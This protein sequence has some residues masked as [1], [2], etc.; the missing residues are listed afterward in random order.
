MNA[1]YLWMF[2]AVMVLLSGVASAASVLDNSLSLANVSVSP[3]PVI[4]GGNVTI[5][6]Q[7]YDSYGSFLNTVNLQA[8]GSYPIINFSP[9]RTTDIANVNPGVNPQQYTYTFA[10]PATTPSGTYKIYFNATYYGLG[11]TEVLASSSMPVTFY[12]QNKPSIKVMLVNPSPPALYSGYNQTVRIEIENVGYGTARNISVSVGAN[13]G[14]SILSSVTTFFI[15]NLT[16]GQ[17]VNESLLVGAQNT[18]SASIFAS[19]VYYSSNLNQRFS[20]VQDLNLSIAPAAQFSVS[21]GSMPEAGPGSTDVPVEFTITNTGTSEAQ[22]VQLNLQSSYPITPVASTAY[23]ADLPAGAST[24]V[25]FLVSVDSQG[26]P[27]NYP[28]TLYEQW[29]QPNGALNQQF[30]GSDNYFITVGSQSGTPALIAAA[31]VVVVIAGIAAFR[32]RGRMAA[33]KQKK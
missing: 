32:L 2:A 12:V 24:N 8:S 25:T 9:A 11:A 30:S 26:V 6:F 5:R 22:Q 4:A 19:S 20:S 29:K 3:N 16:Q 15:S 21:S 17:A 31:I 18:G 27:G 28:V 7:L 14:V 33:K 1:K 10:V 23:I 13:H